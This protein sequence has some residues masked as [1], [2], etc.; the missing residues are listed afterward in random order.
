MYCV[1]LH[2][3]ELSVTQIKMFNESYD[4]FC[5]SGVNLILLGY[6]WIRLYGDEI[7]LRT[8]WKIK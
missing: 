4:W 2:I 6:L 1:H 3:A 5:S 8:K 7:M